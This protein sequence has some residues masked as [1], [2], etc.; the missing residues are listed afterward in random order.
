[1]NVRSQNASEMTLLYIAGYG[2]SGSTVLDM[3]LDSRDGVVGL[4]EVTHLFQYL[5]EGKSCSCGDALLNCQFWSPVIADLKE[6]NISDWKNIARITR[7]LEARPVW[8][9]SLFSRN[10][11]RS[12]GRA[13]SLVFESITKNS[14]VWLVVDSSK[15]TRR[16]ISRLRLLRKTTQANVGMTHLVRDPRAV[17]NSYL[18]GNN[19]ELEKGNA[20]AKR[21]GVLRV[22]PSWILTNL[23]VH[24]TSLFTDKKVRVRYEDL[25]GDPNEQLDRIGQM[26]GLEL[27]ASSDPAKVEEVGSGHGI[28]GN[29]V[30]RQA[31]QRLVLDEQWKQ[32]MG[33]GKRRVAFICWPFM[34]AYG[35]V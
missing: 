30:R 24:I 25:V 32:S 3:L 7:K 15:T 16:T 34:K 14:S 27:L 6:S 20:V 31:R 9:S 26:L 11:L 2:R 21:G 23:A 10:E 28:A 5:D 12:Y 4:S 13:W 22:V 17:V 19:I 1:M 18:K 33:N 29:R 35:Y 8:W